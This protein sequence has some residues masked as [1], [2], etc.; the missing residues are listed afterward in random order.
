M[1]D[2]DDVFVLYPCQ[3]RQ[4]AALRGLSLRVAPGERVVITGP[5]G[6]GKS[7]LVR[8]ITGDLRPSAGR[9]CVLGHDISTSSRHATNTLRRSGV[10]VLTQQI[11]ANLAAELSVLRNVTLQSRLTGVSSA[12]ADLAAS[13][14]L[15]RLGIE[16]LR[17]RSLSTLSAGELQ[18]TAI[19]AVLTHRPQIIVADE[20]T[21]TLDE[22]SARAVFDLLV[23]LCDET[24]ASL[25]VVSHDPGAA[26]VG[27]RVLDIRD[28]RLG[29]ETVVRTGIASQVVD[30]RGWFLLPDFARTHSGISDRAQVLATNG[31]RVVVQRPPTDAAGEAATADA[32]DQQQPDL[33]GVVAHLDM[34]SRSVDG[35]VVLAPISLTV[36]TG[37]FHVIT[38]RSGSGKTTLLGVLREAVNSCAV[39]PSNPGF[40][41]AMSG[42]ENVEMAQAVRSFSPEPGALDGLFESFGLLDLA[43][44]PV[45]QLSGGERQRVALVRALSTGAT[46]VLLDEPTSQLDQAW[47]RRVADVLRQQSRLGRAIVCTSHEAEVVSACDTVHTLQ[48]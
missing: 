30:K 22:R 18:R 41:E 26:R 14:V 23:E 12:A 16:S 31:G 1:I 47:A 32:L 25:V 37:E 3:D 27:H 9:A 13:R 48:R 46:L 35:N 15:G 4:V 34:V 17:D 2:F 45:G 42:R 6:S 10:G 11:T 20:P 33:G 38:G 21:G 24:G 28:G 8:L 44:R 36:R 7:T 39:A 29:R 43:D 40:A 19:A 5:S